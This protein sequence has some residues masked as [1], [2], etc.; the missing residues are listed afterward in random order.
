MAAGIKTGLPIYEASDH[1]GG[2]CT[3][4]V[5]DGF[6][7]SHGGPHFLFGKGKGLEYIKTLVDV[8][9]YERRAG[10]YYNH[11]FPYPFQTSAEK[12]DPVSPGSL[13]SWLRDKFSRESCNLFFN[14]FNKKYTAGLYDE[15]IQADEFKSPPAGSQGFV[16]T[17]GDPVGWLSALVEKMS[18]KCDIHY[19]MQAVSVN[20]DEHKVTF[21]DG[22][23]KKYEKL[24]STIPLGQLLWMCGKRDIELP[25]TSVLVLNIGAE[26]DV[27]TPNEHWL[28]VP[29]C[30]TGFHRICFYS[31]VNKSK[32]P[33]GKVGLAVEIA[34]LPDFTY[35]DFDIP[36][37]IDQ[38]VKEL[39]AWRF[40]G[41]VI[42]VD[43]TY[44]R[45]AYTWLRKKEDREEAL[46]WLKERD[47][48]STGRYGS[49]K[50]Q[51]MIQSIEDGFNVEM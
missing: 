43:P 39:Q 13:K 6:Q 22:S 11:T 14:P 27:N 30:K 42:T 9:E 48:I 8:N 21:R 34:F 38:V 31:N 4:Y 33:E 15:V 2:I 3:T 19:N 32:A 41:D 45:T 17:F 26:P 46:A 25:Y 10:V 5:K 29:F 51:G 47:I 24:I 18:E 20:P 37:I 40:I 36:F 49:W 44:V 23:I 1:S 7:F 35:E 28:Y 12:E 50:F 16:A